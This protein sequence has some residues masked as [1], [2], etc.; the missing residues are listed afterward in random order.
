VKG[1]AYEGPALFSV[2][3]G[4]TKGAAGV[5][6]YL[7]AAAALE[8][9]AFPMFVYDPAAGP[10]LASRL[11]IDG[12]PQVDA[13]WPVH[14]LAYE[15]ENHQ[16]VAEDAAFTFVDFAACDARHA[17]RCE[18]VPRAKNRQDMVAIREYLTREDDGNPEGTPY[19]FMVNGANG[20][21]RVAVDDAL[22]Q[23][24]RRCRS[25]WRNLQELGGINSS[26]ARRLLDRE[27][28]AWEEEKKQTL[29]ALRERAEVAPL[30]PATA[31]PAAA[32][33][34][35]AA[36][37]GAEKAVASPDEPYI[38]T[39]RCTTCNECIQIN[40]RMFA[41]DENKQAYIK[42]IKAGTYRDLVESAESCQVSIIH[43]GK[44]WDPAEANLDELIERAKSFN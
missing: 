3:S 12:N 43:P 33:A 30:P 40:G 18:S 2:F 19:V 4:A 14:R 7:V 35:T 38:E 28:Q 25:M 6:P 22:V 16:R 32:S 17:A 5:P 31:E 26:H 1:L 23:A 15:D 20:L 11:N 39:P 9:R 13:D 34:K 36:A 24:A 8:S 10:D 44:P 27:R 37:S 41:Y 21:R 29:T 42:D